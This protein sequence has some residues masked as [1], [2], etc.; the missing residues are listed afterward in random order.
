MHSFVTFSRR[1]YGEVHK[2]NK[3]GS[4]LDGHS[5]SFEQIF[6]FFLLPVEWTSNRLRIRICRDGQHQ[7]ELQ[8]SVTTL[9]KYGPVHQVKSL[10]KNVCKTEA[11]LSA[12]VIVKGKQLIH[13]NDV[14]MSLKRR[15]K[16]QIFYQF[17]ILKH[18]HILTKLLLLCKTGCSLARRCCVCTVALIM[19]DFPSRV[20]AIRAVSLVLVLPRNAENADPRQF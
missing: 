2:K 6:Y 18:H 3:H 4:R 8:R 1:S 14:Q 16:L 19:V 7:D 20:Q 5:V 12:L 15:G 13:F 9:A 17:L 10:K 11:T